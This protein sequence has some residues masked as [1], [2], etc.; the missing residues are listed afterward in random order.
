MKTNFKDRGYPVLLGEWRAEPK[1][2]HSDLSASDKALNYASCTYWDKYFENTCASYGL[3]GTAWDTPGQLFD[4]TTG[5]IKDQIQINAIL[6]VSCLSPSGSVG[7]GTYKIVARNGGKAM[8]AYG[9]QTANGTQIIQ[10]S[11]GG[12]NNQ[13]W[14][15]TNTGSSYKI[16]GVQSGKSLDING[17][18]SAN[19]TKVQLWDYSGGAN[20]QFALTATDSGYY[21]VTPQNATGSCLDVSG[22]STTDGANV[23]LWGWSGGSNQQWAFQTP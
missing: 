20:Q 11:Y 7:N 1:G 14:I 2:A 6:G 17:W 15:L 23:Q 8:D 9:G 21:R 10:W 16:I 4:W 3:Y 19:G 12:G 5:A 13:K 18:S 22:G